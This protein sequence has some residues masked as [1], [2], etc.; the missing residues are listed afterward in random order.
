MRRPVSFAML[1]ILSAFP[2]AGM[3]CLVPGG[4]T[5]YPRTADWVRR[6]INTGAAV[7][8]SFV[9]TARV[10]GDTNLDVVAAYAGEG[11]SNPAVFIFFQEAV[12]S[13]TAVQVAS[14]AE[15]AGVTA[16]AL[17]DLDGDTHV[18]IVAACNG[19]IVYLHSP[20]DPRNSAG[21]TL[22]VIAESEGAGF[23]QWADVAIGNIDG[24]NGLDI[25]AALAG[26]GRVSWFRSPASNITNGT[27]WLR[28]DIDATTR[29]NAAGVALD[30]FNS[31]G[32]TDVIS[33]AV[34]ESS[35]RVA[36][37]R[38]PSNPQTDAWS[39]FTI[40]NL[41]AASRVITADLNVDGRTDVL[42]VN[43][44]GRQIG[45]YVRP[46]DATA[47]WTG[48]GFL[49]TQYTSALPLDARAADLDGNGQPDVVVGTNTPTTLRWFMPT[50]GQTQTA[51]W[52]ENNIDDI[53]ETV[54]R[55]ALGDID[56]D[57]RPDL[58]APLRATSTA[59]DAI[60]WFENP[61]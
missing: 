23:G 33:T 7:R 15:L 40:G 59:N 13:F 39:K 8:P 42:A 50:P 46:V 20:A 31:D 43:Q 56:A 29:T 52:L 49:L 57:G 47:A 1:M 6:T 54:Q 24:A 35:A 55:I 25:V 9:T 22:S 45:W 60:V 17:G 36:W 38:N 27:G 16:L 3:T 32:K 30:D 26:P 58:V 5:G 51:Q 44:P 21:W 53:N 61:E 18:D 11:A 14:S 19:Q 10:D 41:A 48:A 28:I 37:Y 34:D 2:S 12:D 4:G